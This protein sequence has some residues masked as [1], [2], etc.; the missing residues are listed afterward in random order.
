MGRKG[1]KIPREEK[2]KYAKLCYEGKLSYAEA[3]RQ[4]GVK[5]YILNYL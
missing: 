2:L 5:G 1:I 4:L 3:G